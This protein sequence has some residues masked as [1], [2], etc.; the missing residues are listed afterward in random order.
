MDRRIIK[1]R[2]AI[3]NAYFSLLAEDNTRITITEIARRANIDRKTFYLHYDSV[4]DIIKKTCTEKLQDLNKRLEL[5]GYYKN[6]Y[7]T[8]KLFKIF[9]GLLSKDIDLYRQIAQH[10]NHH[11]F[12][13]EVETLLADAIKSVSQKYI[14]KT[15]DK[16][17]NSTQKLDVYAR[18][19]A[20]GITH[21]Y[22]AWF[23]GDLHMTMEELGQTISDFAAIQSL[24]KNK[25][26]SESVDSLLNSCNQSQIYL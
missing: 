20:A 15:S 19:C 2:E 14:S 4:D 7:D 9:N 13:N 5:Q 25:I 8:D 21:V 22:L 23:K 16:M 12:W 17:V 24:Q 1:T 6:P 10:P 18:F 3:Q 26:C 11:F